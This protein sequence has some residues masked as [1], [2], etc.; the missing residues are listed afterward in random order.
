ML[1]ISSLKIVYLLVDK[2]VHK[3]M[4]FIFE[5]LHLQKI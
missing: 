2:I 3:Y 5:F 4:I 1:I